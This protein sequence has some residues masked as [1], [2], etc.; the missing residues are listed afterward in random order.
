MKVNEKIEFE[1]ENKPYTIMAMDERYLICVRPYTIKESKEDVEKWNKD[2]MDYINQW[3]TEGE[4]EEQ[5]EINGR[6]FLQENGNC[7]EELDEDT[8]CYTIVDLQEQIR[9]A[10]NYYCK[11]NYD[12]VEECEAAL[13]ELNTT[14]EMSL[15]TPCEEKML[16]ISRRN[17]VDLKIKG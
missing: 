7:P 4:S 8:F 1:D 17:R 9:G 5:L 3:D 15:G 12:K 13:V 11:F 2:Y 14:T 16:K 10:D 6:P